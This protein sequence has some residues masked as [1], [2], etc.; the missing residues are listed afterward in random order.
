MAPLLPVTVSGESLSI[1]VALP[2][3]PVFSATIQI[4][5][6]KMEEAGGCIF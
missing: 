4:A 3:I 2:P 1:P 6:L 5:C